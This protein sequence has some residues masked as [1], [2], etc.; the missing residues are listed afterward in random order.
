ME[1]TIIDLAGPEYAIVANSASTVAYL[2]LE[3]AAQTG[4]PPEH[5]DL[6]IRWQDLPDMEKVHVLLSD[7]ISKIQLIDRRKL[8]DAGC[9]PALDSDGLGERL[10]MQYHHGIDIMDLF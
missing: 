7:G 3:I 5:Q 1:L 6:G 4:I 10:R 8:A 9:E 2:K